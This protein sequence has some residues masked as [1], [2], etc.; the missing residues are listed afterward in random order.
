[1]YLTSLHLFMLLPT[2]YGAVYL[3]IGQIQTALGQFLSFQLGREKKFTAITDI[4]TFTDIFSFLR[5]HWG[6]QDGKLF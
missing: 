5:I 4:P 3:K 2:F 1:M 6:I